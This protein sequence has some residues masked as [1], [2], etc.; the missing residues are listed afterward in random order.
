MATIGTILADIG[1]LLAYAMPVLISL[2]VIY[3]IW[4][5][6]QYI[7]AKDDKKKEARSKIIN[8]LIGLFIIVAFWGIIGIV[9]RTFDIDTGPGRVNIVPCVPTANNPC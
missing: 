2:A 7:S 9:T 1:G 3:F 8:G 4:G 6:L 5:V